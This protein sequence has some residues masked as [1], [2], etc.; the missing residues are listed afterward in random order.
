MM[1]DECGQ[2]LEPGVIA[3]GAAYFGS[4]IGLIVWLAV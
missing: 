3:L 1:S 2:E 4:M